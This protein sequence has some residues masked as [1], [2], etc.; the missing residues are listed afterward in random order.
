[1]TALNERINLSRI[2][3]FTF[4]EAFYLNQTHIEEFF[5]DIKTLYPDDLYLISYKSFIG[6]M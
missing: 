2:Q 1:M 4:T 3:Y 6:M 5:R